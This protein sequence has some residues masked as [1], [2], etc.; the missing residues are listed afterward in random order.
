[1]MISTCP[2]HLLLQGDVAK[3]HGIWHRPK[4]VGCKASAG[5][6][7]SLFGFYMK[8]GRMSETSAM[9]VIHGTI[10]KKEGPCLH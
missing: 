1:M 3:A 9:Q 2:Q 8:S 5:A 10:A 4:D 7:D 6:L